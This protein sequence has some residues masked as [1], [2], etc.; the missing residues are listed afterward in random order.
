MDKIIWSYPQNFDLI[1]I[2]INNKIKSAR[3]CF[4]SKRKQGGILIMNEEKKIIPESLKEKAYSLLT[5]AIDF[6]VAQKISPNQLTLVCVF[7]SFVSGVAFFVGDHRAAGFIVLLSGVFHML[8]GA[9]ARKLDKVTKFG[10]L[11]D[12]SMG[13]YC[14]ACIFTGIM[15]Y[16]FS[17]GS[18]IDNFLALITVFAVVGTFMIGYVR[19][20]AQGA[21]VECS[22]SIVE[23]A[24]RI[25]LL[26][27]CALFG[28]QVLSLGVIVI[29]VLANFT[30]YQMIKSIYAS[31]SVDDVAAEMHA[32]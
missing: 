19:L 23:R 32:M 12:S 7:L 27:F 15:F 10:A 13:R 11:F 9:L 18:S 4:K 14:E 20:L 8:D 1:L 2:K 3:G 21:G 5:P 30:V 29:A 31:L 16:Y 28:E 17:V 22:A 25:I 24:E 6:F 26:G